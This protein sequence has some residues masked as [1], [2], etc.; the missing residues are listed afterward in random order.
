[1]LA[2]PNESKKSADLS[3][4]ADPRQTYPFSIVISQWPGFYF[5]NNGLPAGTALTFLLKERI[6]N[7]KHGR[8]ILNSCVSYFLIFREALW[9][10]LIR[11]PKLW[12]KT[13]LWAFSENILSHLLVLCNGAA[14]PSIL[15]G[16]ASWISYYWEKRPGWG[17]G[18]ILLPSTSC[19]FS[20][21]GT[22]L[23]SCQI[24]LMSKQCKHHH[25]GKMPASSSKSS[26]PT[27]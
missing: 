14:C 19:F 6:R 10:K 20:N 2:L 15:S 21:R 17:A 13:R 26:S 23:T 7:W 11:T 9:P 12:G 18:L 25:G 27:L 22:Q 5:H 24:V 8:A 3:K 16:V 1:M 4:V